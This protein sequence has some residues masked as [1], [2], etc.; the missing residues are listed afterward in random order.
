MKPHLHAVSILQEAGPG[1][2]AHFTDDDPEGH[3]GER[4]GP[5]SLLVTGGVQ[6][7]VSQASSSGLATGRLQLPG[8]TICAHHTVCFLKS[9]GS[10]QS[11]KLWMPKGQ[12]KP[13]TL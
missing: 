1:T 5:S 3:R 12:K 4:S 2:L 9:T 7:Q 13:P 8:I 6:T 10:L 11:L